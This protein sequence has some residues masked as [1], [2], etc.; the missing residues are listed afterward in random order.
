MTALVRGEALCL[1]APVEADLPLVAALRND[2]ALQASL[3]GTPHPN[4]PAMARDWMARRLADPN[5]IFFLVADAATDEA[6]GYVMVAGIDPLHRHGELGIC[7]A[8]AHQGRGL[9]REVLALLEGYARDVLA[10]RKIGLQVLTANA[11]AIALYRRA[12]F[13]EVG[14]RQ[15]HHYFQGAYHDVLVMEKL[16]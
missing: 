6:L 8:P 5:E 7:L 14:V 2:L 12:G 1:R 11:R 16:L 10:L 13:R 9:G 4:T 3:L 15:A